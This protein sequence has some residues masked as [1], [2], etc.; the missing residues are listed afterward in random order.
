[1]YQ[2]FIFNEEE[3]KR[4]FVVSDTHFSHNRDFILNKRGYNTIKDHDE[5]LIQKWNETVSQSDTVIHLGDFILG[6][7]QK[8]KEKFY[9]LI[10]RLNGNI[11]YLYGNHNAGLTPVYREIIQEK[12]GDGVDEVY[13]LTIETKGGSFTYRGHNLLIKVEKYVPN[14]TP[15]QVR[16]LF[17][18]HFAHRIWIDSHK[19]YVW[20][21]CG[22][23]HGSD[24][25]SQPDFRGA[26]RLDVGIENFG[27]PI[28][29]EEVEKIMN[30]KSVVKTDRHEKSTNPSF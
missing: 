24:P 9:E 16:H 6:A 29:I 5:G 25:E 14:L 22:H 17:C 28:S 27:R 3:N 13:P 11:V 19:G 26:K 1:M 20:H 23:S 10:N 2:K 4:L 12:Y 30:Q 8:S 7:G 15:K 18:S 21:L